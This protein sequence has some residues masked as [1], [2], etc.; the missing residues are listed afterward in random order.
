MKTTLSESQA[1]A[2]EYTN[3]NVRFRALRLVGSSALLPTLITQFSLDQLSNR[4]VN[5][6]GR[7]ENVLILLTSYSIE[8][9]TL[10][11]TPIF[12]FH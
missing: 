11:T 7:N 3:D 4:V 1:E 5:G 9:M 10:L 2:K 12:N 6:I 8:L